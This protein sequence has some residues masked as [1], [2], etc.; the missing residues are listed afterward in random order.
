[1][2]VPTMPSEASAPEVTITPTPPPPP[3]SP[4]L[5]AAMVRGQRIAVP[6]ADWCVVDHAAEDLADL[7]D[8]AHYGARISLPVPQFSGGPEHVL[9]AYMAQWPFARDEH[10]GLPYVALEACDSGDVTEIRKTAG[11]AFTD[12]ALAHIVAFASLVEQLP[13]E[14]A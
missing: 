5:V 1:M 2:T 7:S 14:S 9:I 4:R 13:E 10:G 8:L 3:V 11:R 6:C 12:Q